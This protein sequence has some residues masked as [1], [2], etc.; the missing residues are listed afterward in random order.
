MKK[1]YACIK[2]FKR[3]AFIEA[4]R[5]M[6]IIPNQKGKTKG[7]VTKRTNLVDDIRENGQIKDVICCTTTK[8]SG[9]SLIV[10]DG[11]HRVGACKLLNIGVDVCI[12]HNDDGT[13][14]TNEQMSM[15]VKKANNR[16]LSKPWNNSVRL[17]WDAT[18]DQNKYAI[19]FIEIQEKY[20]NFDVNALYKILTNDSLTTFS[21]KLDDGLL[22]FK[23]VNMSL[24]SNINLGSGILLNQFKTAKKRGLTKRV[25]NLALWSL[26]LY[27]K[28][29]QV[30]NILAILNDSQNVN[31]ID[32][33]DASSCATSIEKLL[34]L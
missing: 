4:N 21:K 24:L 17:R 34:Q 11:Q 27:A 28:K 5:K 18:F 1:T 19:K 10:L 16:N 7:L 25:I 32:V 30:I 12:L 23:H 6:V 8:D 26:F 31:L 33:V 13:P 20:K 15:I 3:F 22:S 2:E 9:F 29:A 14:L